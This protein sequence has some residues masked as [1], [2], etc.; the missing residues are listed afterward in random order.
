MVEG[1]SQIL[2]KT[3]AATQGWG[4]TTKVYQQRRNGPREKSYHKILELLTL[5]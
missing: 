5:S 2:V 1:T 3:D 4:H